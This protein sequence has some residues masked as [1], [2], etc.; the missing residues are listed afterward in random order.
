MK[1]KK[2][3]I[4]RR[5]LAVSLSALLIGSAS[6]TA[7]AADDGEGEPA[8]F[9][10]VAKNHVFTVVTNLDDWQSD[11]EMSDEDGDGIYTALREG[12]PAGDHL[13]RVRSDLG[14]DHSWGKLEETGSYSQEDVPFSVS[15]KMDVEVSFDTRNSDYRFWTIS[16]DQVEG[17]ASKYVGTSGSTLGYDIA[18]HIVGVVGSFNNWG[19]NSEDLVMESVGDNLYKATIRQE[20]RDTLS[21]KVRLNREWDL[22]WGGTGL[23]SDDYSTDSLIGYEAEVTFCFDASSD[24]HENWYVYV[25]YETIRRLDDEEQK[26]INDPEQNSGNIEDYYYFDENRTLHI[27]PGFE[28]CDGAE[29]YFSYDD[30]VFNVIIEFGVTAVPDSLFDGCQ[31]LMSVELPDWLQRI[32]ANAFRDCDK[33]EG[34]L[35]LPEDVQYIGESAFAGCRNLSVAVIEVG[36]D[37]VSKGAFAN[38]TGLTEL[39]LSSNLRKI[40]A[41]AFRRCQGLTEVTIRPNVTEIAGNAFA[42]CRSDLVIKGVPGTEAEAFAQREHFTFVALDKFE[43]DIEGDGSVA[44]MRYNGID[45][46]VVIPDTIDGRPVTRIG[47]CAFIMNSH[48]RTVYI[49]D[50]VKT[51]GMLAFRD[52]SSLEAVRLSLNAELINGGAF[53]DCAALGSINFPDSL[54]VIGPHAF[55]GC[56]KLSELNEV[57]GL[58]DMGAEVFNDTQWYGDHDDGPV[59][60]GN[61]FIGYKG[62]ADYGTTL[63]IKDGTTGV[64]AGALAG[65]HAARNNIT[66][67]SFPSTLTSVGPNAFWE[68]YNYTEIYIPATITRIED[69]AFGCYWDQ[70]NSRP[71]HID[72]VV[73]HGTYGTA[74]QKYADDNDFEFIS[75]QPMVTS[76]TTGDCAWEY[77]QE[78]H[79]LTISG[80]GAMADYSMNDPAPWRYYKILS[81]D[82]ND[83][84][85][86]IGNDAFMGLGRQGFMFMVYISPYVTSIG[87]NAFHS[88][89]GDLCINGT[90]KSMLPAELETIGAYAFY[91]TELN[92][93]FVPLTVTS[94]GECALGYQ[95]DGEEEKDFAT[96][97]FTIHCHKDSAA[98]SYAQENDIF[99]VLLDGSGFEY[100]VNEDNTVT[101]TG[102]VASTNTIEIPETIDGRPVTEIGEHAFDLYTSNNVTSVILPSTVK[103]IGKQAFWGLSELKSINLPEGLE[104]IGDSALC[105]SLLD[106]DDELV[107]PSSLEYIGDWAF[108]PMKETTTGITIPSGVEHIGYRSV[109]Y[110]APGDTS[111]PIADFVIRGKAG[112]AAE[113]YAQD[114]GFGFV[115]VGDFP[116]ESITLSRYTANL[117]VGRST[118][119]TAT[120]KPDNASNKTVTWTSSDPSVATVDNGKITAASAGTADIIATTS[121]GLTATVKVTVKVQTVAVTGITLSRETANLLVGRSTTATATVTPDNATDKTVTW[122][123][124]DPS[125]ATVDNGKITAVSAG[126]AIITA[127]INNGKTATVTV[128]VKEATVAVTGITLSKTTTNLVK[129]HSTTVTATVSPTNAT[130]KTLTW[131]TSDPAVATVDNGKITAVGGG[132]A[133]I[134]AK[135]NNGKTATVTVNVTVPVESITL[136]RDKANLLVGRSTTATATINPT[137]ATNKTVKWTSSD[138]SVATVTNGKI[139]A[140][141][142]GTA[143]I[144]ATTNNGKTATVAVT[145]K[146]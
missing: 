39:A 1:S 71:G 60:F 101:V 22:N 56:K 126:T 121:N 65:S 35:V 112:T 16:V 142:V 123:S 42:G 2:Y 68:M 127:S 17:S 20:F 29:G 66:A 135:S 128:T 77:D 4:L 47:A 6:A 45:E 94:I 95:Y 67:V 105:W 145:V 107:L 51:V 14:W 7:F 115:D 102:R 146:A 85:T 132:K 141:G 21:C 9:D 144:T 49:P 83:G 13:L 140:V 109:G 90:G 69:G 78:N 113:G 82:V 103:V 72:G 93:V 98:E 58:E 117:L 84:V 61:I 129:G 92:N 12:V 43:Y 86:H 32:G 137:D 80:S 110:Y 136:S 3:S 44:I 138:T 88:V 114:N 34:E 36:V 28:N 87:N 64:A 96:P 76:G 89:Q 125:V 130:N 15:S 55:S 23:Y 38:C 63:R 118:T 143:T 54:T 8:A 52:C 41:A 111:A 46:D 122:T 40:E 50:T 19:Q 91:N 134:T 37:T 5:T 26:P 53:M 79:R 11:L 30:G 74:A 120:V 33:L 25:E 73:I 57:Y 106:L 131:T 75:D 10:G 108:F 24:N 139:T 116:V 104:S 70:E 133:T 59:Y 81:I 119:A 27:L 124:S 100:I 97:G 48:I 18:D 31:E 99:Y 62:E